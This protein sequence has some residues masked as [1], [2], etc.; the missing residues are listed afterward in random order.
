LAPFEKPPDVEI[1]ILNSEGKR[2]AAA[3]VIG[4][5]DRLFELTMHLQ[6]SEDEGAFKV[7]ASMRHR[8]EEVADRV[9]TAFELPDADEATA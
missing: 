1:E 8:G 7:V 4:V 2:I 5:Q 6:G 3:S 9:E